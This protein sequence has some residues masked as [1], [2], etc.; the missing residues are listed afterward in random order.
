MGR[1]FDIVRSKYVVA[2]YD[3]DFLQMIDVLE[4]ANL[5][6][7]DYSWP[8]DD[9][10]DLLKSDVADHLTIVWVGSPQRTFIN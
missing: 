5:S 9:S 7:S 4:L 6:I 2:Y 3:I 8:L 10:Y 1:T